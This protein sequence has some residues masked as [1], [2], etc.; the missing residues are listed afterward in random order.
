MRVAVVVFPGTNCDFD[1]HHVV[2]DV[3]GGQAEYVWHLETDLDRFDAIV[4]P[5]GFS[6]GDYLRTGVIASFS[7][8]MA[9]VARA[10]EEGRPVLGICNGFQI[11]CEA[12]LLPGALRRNA[13]LKFQCQ[14][15][16]L[17]VE[18][19]AAPFTGLCRPGQ[20][21][22]VPINHGEGNYYCDPG[23][24]TELQRNGQLVFRYCGPDGEVS[25]QYN[26]NGSAGNIA[27]IRNRRGNVLGMMPHPERAAETVLGS[28][29]GRVIFD[30]LLAA[31]APAGG[32]AA[33]PSEG[34]RAR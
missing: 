28:A 25:D 20:V 13:S 22:R 7:P 23:T 6:Y 21:L 18:E 1:V 30:S 12:G 11:L 9:S 10:A 27:G 33:T 4:L 26:A 32:R 3:C 24:Y 14:H 17:R 5:G 8:V 2:N 16:Y 31:L 15:V 34:V 19:A 29:D